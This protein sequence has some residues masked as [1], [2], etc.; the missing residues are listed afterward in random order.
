MERASLAL[1]KQSEGEQRENV[2]VEESGNP[3]NP[4]NPDVKLDPNG[5]PLRPQPTDDPFGKRIH[6]IL[7]TWSSDNSRSIELEPMDQT[8]RSS[9]SFISWIPG[10]LLPG[11]NCESTQ[12][13]SDS[14]RL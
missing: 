14:N 8:S 4:G 13:R 12:T 11:S 7:A 2:G 6:Y 3:G 9:P 10:T 5:F 1:E